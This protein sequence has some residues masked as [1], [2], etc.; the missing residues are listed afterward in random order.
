MYNENI[1]LLN[2]TLSVNDQN[3]NLPLAELKENVDY[4]L[5]FNNGNRHLLPLL[6]GNLWDYKKDGKRFLSNGGKFDTYKKCQVWAALLDFKV[7]NDS[8]IAFDSV[9]ERMVYLET[10]GV[11]DSANPAWLEREIY[12]PESLRGQQLLFALKASGSS[13]LSGWSPANAQTETI[14]I[15]VIGATELIQKFYDVGASPNF[16]YYN[17]GRNAPEMTTVYVP[18]NVD[19]N[20]ATVKVKIFRTSGVGFLHIDKVF[21]GGLTLPYEGFKIQN[22]DINEFYDFSKG[23]SKINATTLCGHTISDLPTIYGGSFVIS[24]ANKS[25]IVTYE[26]LTHFLREVLDMNSVVEYPVADITGTN[27]FNYLGLSQGYIPLVPGERV[28]QIDHGTIRAGVTSKPM[29]NVVAPNIPLGEITGSSNV[30]FIHSIFDIKQESFKVVLSDSPTIT[31]YQLSWTIGNTFSPLDAV[32]YMP[33]TKSINPETS[34]YNI[35]FDY[36]QTFGG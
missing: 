20:T 15:E 32:G 29:V 4:V 22:I 21:I 25:D 30:F 11:A 12:I 27:A 7:V 6:F 5:S 3:I 31:G 23:E 18:F 19:L 33:V 13:S 10:Q 8:R 16:Y 1:S 35:V 28:Y 17:A 14:G 2:P 36:E 24:G 34:G 26:G 9:G